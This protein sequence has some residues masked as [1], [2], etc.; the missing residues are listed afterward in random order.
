MLA[1]LPKIF[2]YSDENKNSVCGT[3]V[4]AGRE[5]GDGSVY[6]LSLSENRRGCVR[7]RFH[8]HACFPVTGKGSLSAPRPLPRASRDRRYNT[9]HFARQSGV[10]K[11][12]APLD[13]PGISP[14]DNVTDKLSATSY[15]LGNA[16][17][18]GTH[19]MFRM[20][21]AAGLRHA[22][23]DARATGAGWGNKINIGRRHGQSLPPA[24]TPKSGGQR[25]G[26]HPNTARFPPS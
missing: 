17:S 5:T 1:F 18:G 26:Q 10:P 8:T 22:L 19:P 25:T 21:T 4:A 2:V 13:S 24:K 6:L 12:S 23:R 11:G 9:L 15:S 14:A 20:C 16:P 7:L 3:V